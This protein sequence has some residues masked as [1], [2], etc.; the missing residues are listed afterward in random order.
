MLTLLYLLFWVITLVFG[1][2]VVFS[3]RADLA[4]FN[5]MGVMVGIAAN[6]LIMGFQFLGFIQVIVYVGAVM[7]LFLFVIMLLNLRQE[8]PVLWSGLSP[9][10]RLGGIAGGV[11]ALLLIWNFSGSNLDVKRVSAAPA[12]APGDPAGVQAFA[13]DLLE[14]WIIPFEVTS[15]LLLAAVIGAIL[16]A[17]RREILTIDTGTDKKRAEVAA[18]KIATS[19]TK[20]QSEAH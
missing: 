11:A 2:L 10:Q 1:L 7:V 19:A 16:I 13:S 8:E 15:L 6:F 4:A 9:L 3:R 5:L 14:K 12:L 17:R 18:A 20:T